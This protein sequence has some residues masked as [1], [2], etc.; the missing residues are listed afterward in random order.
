MTQTRRRMAILPPPAKD[1]SIDTGT[2]SV[3]LPRLA[4]RSLQ[5]SRVERFKRRP[6]ERAFSPRKGCYDTCS[7]SGPTCAIDYGIDTEYSQCHYSL[8]R[9]PIR[10]ATAVD[11]QVATSQGVKVGKQPKPYCLEAGRKHIKR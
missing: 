7:P 1:R 8:A 6:N 4:R 9:V 10:F 2:S 11:L 5:K 3:T